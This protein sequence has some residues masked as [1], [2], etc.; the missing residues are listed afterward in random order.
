MI[1]NLNSVGMGLAAV[2]PEFYSRK[3]VGVGG[4]TC[5]HEYWRPEAKMARLVGLGRD[6]L[7]FP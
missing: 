3:F 2:A 7:Q 5:R 4:C 6:F 1:P